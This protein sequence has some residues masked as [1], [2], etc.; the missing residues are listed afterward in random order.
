MEGSTSAEMVQVTKGTG[1]F[2][3]FFCVW[4][5]AWVENAFMVVGVRLKH[6]AVLHKEGLARASIRS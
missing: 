2:S 6:N 5:L 3:S 4:A 1:I